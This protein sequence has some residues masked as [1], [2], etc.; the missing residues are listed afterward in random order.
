MPA[1]P[2]GVKSM[3]AGRGKARSK[4]SRAKA[5]KART[6]LHKKARSSKQSRRTVANGEV[7]FKEVSGYINTDSLSHFTGSLL[8]GP[9]NSAI[10]LGGQFGGQPTSPTGDGI[11]G[12]AQG[13]G[14]TNVLSNWYTPAYPECC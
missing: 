7:K 5:A 13:V 2:R 11:P 12:L 4:A 10:F 1:R 8:A 9:G 3:Y 6:A 14:E